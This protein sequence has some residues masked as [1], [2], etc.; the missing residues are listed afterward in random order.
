MGVIHATESGPHS[1]KN[2]L[3]VSQLL[4]V[5]YTDLS[6]LKLTVLEYLSIN[7]LKTE[8]SNRIK[9]LGVIFDEKLKWNIHPINVN[10]KILKTTFIFEQLKPLSY[11]HL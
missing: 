7:K 3:D 9:Y 10:S 11:F 2:W 6:T 4:K 8:C 1:D 5:F